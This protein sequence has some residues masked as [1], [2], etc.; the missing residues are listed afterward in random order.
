M[1]LLAAVVVLS[2]VAGNL[3]LSIGVKTPSV[4]LISAGVAILIVW[5]LCR[6]TLMSWADLSYILPITSVGYILNALAG[7][8]FLAEHISGARW[9]G[10]LLIVAGMLVVSR[11]SP[12][13]QT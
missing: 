2:N 5:T 3:L 10:T 11:T 8:F 6:M 12:R 4:L 1:K 7:K 13:T 9:C